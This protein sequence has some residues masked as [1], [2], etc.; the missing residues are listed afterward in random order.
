MSEETNINKLLGRVEEWYCETITSLRAEL[1]AAVAERD[2]FRAL[3]IRYR[4]ETPPGHQ[5]HMIAGEVD[6]ALAKEGA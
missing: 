6:A 3:L 4:K 2:R 1:A 5:P